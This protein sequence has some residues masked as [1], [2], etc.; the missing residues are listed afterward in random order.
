N[1]ALCGYGLLTPQ[2]NTYTQNQFRQD[3][4]MMWE[5]DDAV[6]GAAC[7]NDASSYP[8]PTADGGVGKRHGKGGGIVLNVSGAVQFIRYVA[9]AAEAKDP[10]KNRLWCNPGTVNGH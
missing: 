7:Y 2:G 3:A 5:P 9:W 1:G 6:Y 8:D 4:F 10:N